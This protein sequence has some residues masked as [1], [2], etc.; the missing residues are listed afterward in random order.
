M[1]GLTT[2]ELDWS[3]D[4]CLLKQIRDFLDLSFDHCSIQYCPRSCNKVADCL[5]M[6]GASMVSSG[7]AVFLSQ[8]PAF[9]SD[10]VYKDQVGADV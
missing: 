2:F 3:V 8:V 10:Q 7:S 9:V 1:R 4:G 5:A 6:Y